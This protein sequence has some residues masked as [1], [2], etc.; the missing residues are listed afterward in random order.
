MLMYVARSMKRWAS[1]DIRLTISP[2]VDVF[3]AELVMTRALA[4]D[5]RQGGSPEHQGSP[6][7]K[8]E[9]TSQLEN[10]EARWEIR[11]GGPYIFNTANVNHDSGLGYVELC[12]SSPHLSVDGPNDGRLEPH[13]RHEADVEVLVQDQC[14]QAGCEEEEAGIEEA[15]PAGGA[16][17]VD[18]VNEQPREEK[19]EP[20][21]EGTSGWAL[22]LAGPNIPPSEAGRPQGAATLIG[23][24]QRH[25]PGSRQQRKPNRKRPAIS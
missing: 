17:V 10:L 25:L 23:Q 3:R 18:K 15:M 14:L 21:Q 7:A 6:H 16:L 8:H 13:P 5:S 1:T 9:P 2:T 24:K 4:G 12:L 22:G 11:A 20:L 19:V